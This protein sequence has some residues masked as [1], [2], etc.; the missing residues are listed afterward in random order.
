METRVHWYTRTKEGYIPLTLLQ[1]R[2]HTA[3]WVVADGR[4]EGWGKIMPFSLSLALQEEKKKDML[5]IAL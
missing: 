2:E 3:G 1:I 5:I 4:Y